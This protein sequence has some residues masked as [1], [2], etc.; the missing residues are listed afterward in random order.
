MKNKYGHFD[1]IITP[2]LIIDKNLNRRIITNK[3]AICIAQDV[4]QQKDQ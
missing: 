3:K 1:T 2:R 4:K